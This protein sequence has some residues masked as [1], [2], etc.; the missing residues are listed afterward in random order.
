M[1]QFIVIS[2][3]STRNGLKCS[4]HNSLEGFHNSS[5]E[6]IIDLGPIWHDFLQTAFCQRNRSTRVRV[7]DSDFVITTHHHTSWVGSRV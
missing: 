6:V 5:H 7:K 4:I 1:N 2:G 3:F